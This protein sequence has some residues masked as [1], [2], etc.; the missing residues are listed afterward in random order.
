MCSEVLRT[1]EADDGEVHP[2]GFVAHSGQDK[3]PRMAEGNR[4]KSLGG[5]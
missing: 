3:A 4:F 2:K 5:S 1:W